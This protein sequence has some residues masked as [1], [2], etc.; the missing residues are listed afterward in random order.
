M[1]SPSPSVY[2]KTMLKSKKLNSNSAYTKIL[3]HIWSYF[4]DRGFYSSMVFLFN[5]IIEWIW[6]VSH[7]KSSFNPI[8]PNVIENELNNKIYST[9]Y[10]PT[11]IIPFIKLMKKLSPLTDYVFVDFGAGKG[12]T[13]ILAKECGFPR[14][15]GLEFSFSLYKSAQKNIQNYKKKKGDINFE[16]LN[17]DASK[18]I[19]QKEDNFF[20][21]FNPFNEFILNQC[22]NNIHSSLKKNPRKAL[23]VYQ[24]NKQ[25]NT[26]YITAKDFFKLKEIFNSRGTRFYIYEYTPT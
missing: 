23:L 12:R 10:V 18:Y 11:P 7:R 26:K 1:I 4:H 8:K 24:I 16:L 19:V 6:F 15:K 9:F 25:D 14:V 21:F 22:L 5:S 20:Y 13:M 17:L 3:N 2:M